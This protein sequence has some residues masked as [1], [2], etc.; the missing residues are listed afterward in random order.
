MAKIYK[1]QVDDGK[2]SE[3]K[4]IRLEPGVK[5]QGA[6]VRL[7][8]QKGARYELQQERKDGNNFAP[9]QLRVER[10]GKNLQLW[11]D[12]SKSP[13]VVIEGFYEDAG[14]TSK[15]YGTAENGS[16]Y[17]YVPQD[18]DVNSMPQQLK[19][20]GSLVA[21]A[22]GGPAMPADFALS[23]LPLVAAAS[24][25]VGGW[26]IA[27]GALLAAA[28]GGGAG[29]GGGA[30]KDVTAPSAAKVAVPEAANGVNATEAADGT[31]VLVTLPTDAIAGDTVT[32]VVTKPDGTKLTLSHALTAD[33]MAAKTLTQLVPA[34]ELKD[35]N[36]QYMD[37][38]W[39]L[40]TTVTD[41][42]N[43]V[44]T[45]VDS[46]FVLDTSAPGNAT[47]HLVH[48]D[49]NDTGVDKA[50][51][52]TS[53]DKPYVEGV[54]EKG[55][56]VTV[57]VNGKSYTTTASSSDGSYKVQVTDALDNGVYTPKITA[58]DAAG[59]SST[60]DG[61]PFTVDKDAAHN[62]VGGVVSND[63]NTG[64]T[65]A[66]VITAASEDTGTSATDFITSDKSVVISGTVANFDSAGGN[67]GDWVHV[68]VFNAQGVRVS[69][70]YVKPTG[71][72]WTMSKPTSDLPDGDYTV[73][74][75]IVD[76]AGNVVKSAQDQLLKISANYLS[77]A[78]DAASAQ[79]AG[80]ASDKSAINAINPTGNV[81]TNDVDVKATG[82]TVQDIKF[83]SSVA[84]VASGTTSA[85]GATINGTY[86]T[87]KIG[88][89][90]SYEY[91]VDQA[92]AQHLR[93]TDAPTEVFG[94]TVTRDGVTSTANLTV[95]VHGANDLASFDTSTDST[96]SKTLAALE[97]S[98]SGNVI[99]IDPDDREGAFQIPNSMTSTYGTFTFTQSGS[100]GTWS[101]VLDPNKSA[102]KALKSGVTGTDTLTLTSSDGS[103]S[104][105][106]TVTVTGQND[107]PKLMPD[108]EVAV[109]SANRN[110]SD[111][112]GLS[113]AT[114]VKDLMTHVQDDDQA[115]TSLGIAITALGE[116]GNLWYSQDHGAHW[117]K[118]A[119]ASPS[120]A[121]L[122]AANDSTYLYF[123][124]TNS[125]TNFFDAS[126]VSTA[127]T[128]TAWDMTSGTAGAAADAG[129][130]GGTSAFS[131][132]S[133]TVRVNDVFSVT[134]IASFTGAV[135]GTGFDTLVINPTQTNWTLDL[136]T[137]TSSLP[138]SGIE[139][140]DITGTTGNNTV[141][142][143]LASLTQADSV[144]SVHKLY[145]TGDAG[146]AVVL[147][148]GPTNWT[149]SSPTTETVGTVVY[150]VY[151]IDST[152]D[153]LINQ[154]ITSIS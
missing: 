125:P 49:A 76:A 4:S 145:I 147:T 138:L 127:F 146:D 12:G 63:Q 137:A 5:N 29:G 133:Q 126:S 89:D 151:H 73:K 102:Y 91:V 30:A 75:N 2:G 79:E 8:A 81:L 107:A 37:G 39:T 58:T 25:G 120:T 27:G 36:G 124:Q 115:S 88:A 106:V 149:T 141:K 122:L 45:P 57:V 17:E 96:Y 108:A 50:D 85:N 152:H 97:T 98:C 153:L 78:A 118:I 119:T 93:A 13:D 92:K 9:D 112:T 28:A 41:A 142:L 10:K 99:V 117:T 70:E 143:N 67:A 104:R 110:I 128:F 65:T 77:A 90:G 62:Y 131:A 100:T 66:V 82:R 132:D 55:A 154:A 60:V 24:G 21:V 44:S 68:Q 42:A 46:Q 11:F 34:S 19:E 105:S 130:S 144:G 150:N 80:V 86:G 84:T 95:T 116:S 135:G 43:N 1:I 14:S 32:T 6:P 47:G 83:G 52:I 35:A 87:L 51:S 54:A 16:Q 15:L 64:S 59:N 33:D 103:A 114:R 40:T 69:N 72:A 22:L 148:G 121:L 61:T 56:T 109:N 113:G 18:P 94:Y 48:D 3:I 123:Q 26:A 74:A 20:G 7:V 140:I 38:T 136:S 129:T 53:Q 134:D 111:P 71:N 23:A 139:K 31:P 101:Y